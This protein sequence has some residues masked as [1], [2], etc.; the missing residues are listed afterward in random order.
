MIKNRFLKLVASFNRR[1]LLLVLAGVITSFTASG[2]HAFVGVFNM[3]IMSEIE[4][5]LTEVHWANPHVR[6]WLLSADGVTWEIESNS[7]SILRRMDVSSELF[8]VGDTIRVAGSPALDGSH[9]MWVNNALLAD[10]RE[11][12]LRPG[13]ERRWS[14]EK[15][16]TEAVWMADGS[17]SEEG[18]GEASIFRVWSTHFASSDRWLWA[19]SYP[20]TESAARVQAEYNPTVNNPIANCAP[21]GMPWIMEQPYPMEFVEEDGNILMRLE[22]YD[23]VRTLYMKEEIPDNISSSRLGH[24]V[25]HWEGTTLVVQTTNIDYPQFNATGIPQS[26]AIELLENFTPSADGSRLAYSVIVTDPATFTEP[27]TLDKAW[28]NRPGEMVR[29]YNCTNG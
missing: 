4:G 14:G 6:F 9:Q 17:A 1:V 10:G 26:R 7:L 11:V 22:E 23:A 18:D 29:P 5:E 20:F 21:K 19:D 25:A 27:I 16:G 2:H 13:V 12:V 8:K 28:V 3:D 24:S 15:L